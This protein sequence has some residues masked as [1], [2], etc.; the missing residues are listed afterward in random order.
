MSRMPPAIFLF[1]LEGSIDGFTPS[2]D[3]E[4][5]GQILL[6]G[7]RYSLTALAT[8]LSLALIR[9]NGLHDVI[10]LAGN[11]GVEIGEENQPGRC[12]AMIGK[13]TALAMADFFP[14]PIALSFLP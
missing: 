6:K 12:L 5:G 11:W 8:S 7:S 9:P 13:R 2:S 1:W 10:H 4:I 3:L 14:N